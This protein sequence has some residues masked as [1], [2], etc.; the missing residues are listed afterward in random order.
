MVRIHLS[1][2][3]A[4]LLSKLAVGW[5]IIFPS[6][7][8]WDRLKDTVIGTGPFIWKEYV[9]GAGSTTVRNPDYFRKG[10]PC[11]DGMQSWQRSW[12]RRRR[13]RSKP[14]ANRRHNCWR[15][16]ATSQANSS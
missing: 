10:Y 12:V 9:T 3:A 15:T 6:E 4:G 7:L 14:D 1:Q 13:Q 16:Q 11:L 5:A 2:P 8:P